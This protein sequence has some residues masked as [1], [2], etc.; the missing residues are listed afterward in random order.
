[1]KRLYLL[2]VFLI[3]LMAR[4]DNKTIALAED[5]SIDCIE[6]SYIESLCASAILKIQ[7]PKYFHYGE[8][9][10]GYQNVF[11]AHLPCGTGAKSERGQESRK[12]LVKISTLPFSGND[13]VQ[14]TAV[15][16]YDGTKQYF[17]KFV[18]ECAAN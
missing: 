10:K 14:C 8:N 16:S 11:F 18:T 4:C 17:V 12:I 9:V 6:V 1:M 13:C 2:L 15:P 3:F 7:D 5:T